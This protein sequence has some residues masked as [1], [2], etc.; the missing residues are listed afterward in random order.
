MVATVV[1]R[2]KKVE[3]VILHDK[4]ARPDPGSGPNLNT[5]WVC[6]ATR[7]SSCIGY[8][9]LYKYHPNLTD[10]PLIESSPTTNLEEALRPCSSL[11]GDP[12]LT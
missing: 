10:F 7:R 5:S 6:S 1:E 9:Y 4:E 3:E 12:A 8:N 11:G 2:L